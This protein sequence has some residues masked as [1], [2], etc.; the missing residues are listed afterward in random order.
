MPVPTVHDTSDARVSLDV[1]YL[2]AAVD[3]IASRGKAERQAYDRG[4]LAG[5]R[6]G[7]HAGLQAGADR[8]TAA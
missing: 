5:F 3:L 2:R 8:R 6:D 1:S 4:R 7:W